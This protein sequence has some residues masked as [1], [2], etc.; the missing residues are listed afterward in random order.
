MKGVDS[1]PN[2]DDNLASPLV[3]NVSKQKQSEL[4]EPESESSKLE[5]LEAKMNY[6]TSFA[7]DLLREDAVKK[8][9]SATKWSLITATTFSWASFAY[10]TYVC[11]EDSYMQRFVTSYAIYFASYYATYRTVRF[12]EK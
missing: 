6:N 4:K 9:L 3:C 8:Q 2:T 11:E 1:N 10:M 12:F 7:N 5:G